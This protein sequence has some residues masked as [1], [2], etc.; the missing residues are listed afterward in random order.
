MATPLW[1]KQSIVHV[2]RSKQFL[3]R[4]TNSG[5]LCYPV[6]FQAWLN[7]AEAFFTT[8]PIDGMSS[9]EVCDAKASPP[10]SV[11]AFA[12]M[13]SAPS[14]SPDTDGNAGSSSSWSSSSSF[15]AN[16]DY[17][18]SS[19]SRSSVPAMRGPADF[20]YTD[21][22]D[23]GNTGITVSLCSSFGNTRGSESL[24]Q[25]PQSP[26]SGFSFGKEDEVEKEET[27]IQEDQICPL[28]VFP[29]QHPSPP[30]PPLSPSHLSSVDSAD[31]GSVCRSSSMNV[32]PC[33]TGYL[34]LKELN[35][36]F[37]NKSI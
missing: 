1:D 34:T 33:R 6:L 18:L 11:L 17:F 12:S 23:S 29:F 10:S 36:T 28:L 24:E 4:R 2:V 37:S 15:Y 13:Q 35:M 26:D 27:E 19:T 22:G 7:P 30:P 31:G 21:D 3:L 32:Q 8:Q 5:L 20:T 16:I 9:V 14:A 25:E